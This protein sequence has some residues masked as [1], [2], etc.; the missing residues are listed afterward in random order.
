[1]NTGVNFQMLCGDCGSLGIKIE[2][3]ERASREAV[4]Y[5]ADCGAQRGTMGA[6]RDLAVRT[7]T[8]TVLPIKGTGAHNKIHER[9]RGATYRATEP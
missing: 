7:E 4:V 2:N 5:C 6:L 1:M 9:Y 8:L 3:P